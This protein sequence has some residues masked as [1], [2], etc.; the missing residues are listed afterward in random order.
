MD[1]ETIGFFV[2]ATP[3]ITIILRNMWHQ[4][5][6]QKQI[7]A[8]AWAEQRWSD[9]QPGFKQQFNLLFHPEKYIAPYDSPALVKAKQALLSA[10]PQIWRRHWIGG[11]ILVVGA[12]TGIAVSMALA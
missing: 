9:T 12:I 2:G 7:Q 6:L 3:G 5:M 4:Q 11:A 1:T 8:A 10:W